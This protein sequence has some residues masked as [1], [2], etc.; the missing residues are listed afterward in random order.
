MV[1]GANTFPLFT[2]QTRPET[3]PGA[4]WRNDNTKVTNRQTID[5]DGRELGLRL[6]LVCPLA[7]GIFDL[8]FDPGD[9]MMRSYFF[10]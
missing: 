10:D 7:V 2:I 5:L 8:K 4:T 3:P 9:A 6:T 1:S